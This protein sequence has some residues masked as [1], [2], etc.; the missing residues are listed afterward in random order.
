M[1][2]VVNGTSIPRI[3][4]QIFATFLNECW[5]WHFVVVFA[6]DD[7]GWHALDW[8]LHPKLAQMAVM[9]QTSF[10]DTANAGHCS[11]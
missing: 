3:Y 2:V 11:L 10:V 7:V 1:S 8:F 9:A 4:L 6:S 5:K